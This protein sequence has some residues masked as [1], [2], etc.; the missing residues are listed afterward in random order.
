M[1]TLPRSL[2]LLVFL[3]GL[4]LLVYQVLGNLL[5]PIIW[6]IIMV[7]ATWPP[8]FRVKTGFMGRGDLAASLMVCLLGIAIIAPLIG[9]TSVIQRES[10]DFIRNLPGWLEQRSALHDSLVRLPLIGDELSRMVDQWGDIGEVMKLQVIPQ[11]RGL[12]RRLLD[13]LGGAGLVAGQWML[14][15]FLMFFLYRDGEALTA[16]L[17]H[18][19]RLG[20]GERADNYVD[21]AV[22]T[23]RAVLYGFVLTAIVQGSVAGIGYWGVQMPAPALL[24]LTT[25]AMAMIPFGAP[26]VWVLCV[27]WLFLQG[28]TWR[29]MALLLWGSLVVSWVDNIV[30]PLVISQATRIPFALVVLGIIGGLVSYG[31]L[32]L[33]I[34]P[35]VLAIA[36][37]A[38][39]EWLKTRTALS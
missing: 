22:R 12:S 30:R 8:Y 7:Y 25:I 4:S 10:V 15:L 26:V 24:T 20:L 34:G 13:M 37:A 28:E 36:H 17:R 31:F 1:N 11:L 14:T 38:W 6:A 3:A 29:A 16:E 33:F 39:K 32:G 23:S 35:V 2:P 27:L 18:G 21:I 9:M 5:K 19:L